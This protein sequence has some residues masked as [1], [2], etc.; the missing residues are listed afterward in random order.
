MRTYILPLLDVVNRIR[1]N[2]ELAALPKTCIATAG[3]SLTVMLEQSLLE[4]IT[5]QVRRR[6]GALQGYWGADEKA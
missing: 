3:T 5:V 2:R 4:G 6:V 1:F